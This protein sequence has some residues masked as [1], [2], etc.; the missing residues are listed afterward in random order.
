MQFFQIYFSLTS[1]IMLNK[2]DLYKH[3][4]FMQFFQIYFSSTSTIHNIGNVYK[5]WVFKQFSERLPYASA[6]CYVVKNGYNMKF[7]TWYLV[8]GVVLHNK[9]I[10]FHKCENVT[11]QNVNF[12]VTFFYTI[13]NRNVTTECYLSC[14]IFLPYKKWKC[15][16]TKC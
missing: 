16:N 14:H 1:M 13:G 5:D 3:W 10:I 2:Y 15:D 8:N 12:V 7:F 6:T 9:K 4:V 11:T